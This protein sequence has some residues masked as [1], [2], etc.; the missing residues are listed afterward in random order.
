ML[1]IVLFGA[2]GAGKGTQAA[3]LKARYELVHLST[4]DMLRAA[5][6]SESELGRKVAAIMNTGALV[7]DEIVNELVEEQVRANPH[8]NGF[9]FDGYPRTVAQAKTLDELLSGLGLGVTATLLLDVPRQELIDRLHKR[10]V[11]KGRT[12]DTP[13]VIANRLD[14]YNNETLPVAAYYEAQGKVR[15][16]NGFGTEGSVL[17]RLIATI[18]EARKVAS[19]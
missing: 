16:V 10:A 19:H 6:K 18:A 12:D 8:A 9:I 3:Y 1:N 2:P 17:D 14:V 13:E 15:E 11:E 5:K 4:G 7:S